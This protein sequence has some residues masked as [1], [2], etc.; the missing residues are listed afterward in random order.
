[1]DECALALDDC[2]AN[3]TCTNTD[4]G[5]TCACDAGYS[6]DGYTCTLITYDLVGTGT[7]ASPRHWSDGSNAASCNAYRYPSSPYLYS[8][9]TGSGV[10]TIDIGGGPFDVYCDM[11]NDG[12]GWTLVVNISNTTNAHG[13]TT[14]AYGDIRQTTGA[15]KLSDATINAL[16][17]IGYWR[18]NCGATYNAFVLNDAVTW[19]SQTTNGYNWR[20]DRGRDGVF[21]Y[22][23]NR[24]GYVFSDYPSY[25]PGHTDYAAVSSAE[26][27]G[28]Y[29]DGEGWN[30]N[31]NLWAK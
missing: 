17:T 26:G 3:A 19:I 25:A 28:C 31:G 1:M 27:N 22:A 29:V 23:A 12:G 13:N 16:T 9:S 30:K 21:E 6:G 5:F 15:A 18:Y 8:G 20:V 10:Y 2:G 14:G 24:A 7:T 4:G 11:V